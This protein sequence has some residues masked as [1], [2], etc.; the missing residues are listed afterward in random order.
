MFTDDGDDTASGSGSPEWGER[1]ASPATSYGSLSRSTSA[2]G[3]RKAPPPPPSRSKKPAPPIPAKRGNSLLDQPHSLQSLSLASASVP[4]RLNNW[5]T[6]RDTYIS[7]GRQ[8]I[9][10]VECG[11]V[12]KEGHKSHRSVQVEAFGRLFGG[13]S[14][15][16]WW[17]GS[18]PL[19]RVFS[20]LLCLIG[21]VGCKV[22]SVG[23]AMGN[24]QVLRK[25]WRRGSARLSTVLTRFL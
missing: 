22:D 23:S 2:L 13:Q 24:G 8:D 17:T 25:S 18:A 12:A 11:S 4:G 3:T 14:W 21:R 9:K 16:S 7:F 10:M 15:T 20:S 5:G 6:S 1:S 19:C